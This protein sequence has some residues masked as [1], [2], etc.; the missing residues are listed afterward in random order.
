[1]MRKWVESYSCS[2]ANLANCIRKCRLDLKCLVF[3]Q[4]KSQLPIL[5][6]WEVLVGG[7][8]QTFVVGGRGIERES[9]SL[10]LD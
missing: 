9:L 10:N 3:I 5:S 1:M 2:C 6:D 7:V 8:L 4:K